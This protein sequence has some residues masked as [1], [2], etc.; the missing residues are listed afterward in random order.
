MLFLDLL[1]LKVATMSFLATGEHDKHRIQNFASPEGRD[2][3]YQ[4]IQKEWTVL[5]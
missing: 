5:E 3:M 4:Y 1:N 2:D